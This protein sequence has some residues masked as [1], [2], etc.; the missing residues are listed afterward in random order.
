MLDPPFSPYPPHIPYLFLLACWF[1]V[2]MCKGGHL[3]ILLEIIF[4]IT[5]GS[6]NACTELYSVFCRTHLASHGN[7]CNITMYWYT[8]NDSIHFYY[9]FKIL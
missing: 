1:D 8:K 7:T 2:K 4:K 3:P 9:N 6:T 5:L